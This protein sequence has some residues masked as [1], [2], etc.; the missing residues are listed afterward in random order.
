MAGGGGS[1]NHGQVEIF[2]LNRATPRLVKTIPLRVPVLCLEY[3]KEPCPST[4]D[5]EPEKIQTA[6][7]IGNIIC[8]G[9]QDGR[10]VT[11]TSSVPQSG[12]LTQGTDTVELFFIYVYKCPVSPGL[13][14]IHVYSSV[15]T[16]VQC[17]LTLVNPDSCPVLCL[18]HSLSFLFAGLA[19]GKVAVYHRKTGGELDQFQH[20]RDAGLHV[21]HSQYYAAAAKLEQRVLNHC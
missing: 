17:L 1:S 14:S 3:V 7:K 8:V 13:P 11:S 15:D 21:T 2:S 9:L 5:K 20:W 12:E 16:A 6:A 19:N 18:K 10:S 4:E